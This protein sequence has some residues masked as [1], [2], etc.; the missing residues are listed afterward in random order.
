MSEILTLDFYLFELINGKWHFPLFDYLL[1]Y[2]RSKYFWFPFYV[3][4]LSFL[5]I[6][7]KK[8]GLYIVVG[9][10]FSLSISDVISSHIVK[11]SV[12]RVRPCNDVT[13]S[14]DVRILVR[15]GSGYSFTSSHAANHFSMAFFLIFSLGRILKR[16]K[17]PLLFWAASIAYAQVYVGV[18][19]PT[20]IFGGAILGSFIGSLCGYFLFKNLKLE[21]QLS[22][23]NLMP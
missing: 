11:K 13:I 2:W 9:L 7:F 15:C 19:F 6:N 1:P 10:L 4:L 22:S 17:L 14:N 16:I 20:D 8:A 3:F 5:V 23:E 12:K 21:E 18:H